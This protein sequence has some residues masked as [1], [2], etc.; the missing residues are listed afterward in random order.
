MTRSQFDALVREAMRAIPRRFRE[1]MQNVEILVEE[2]PDP[3]MLAD[4]GFDS[5]EVLALCPCGSVDVELL[6]GR[7]LR[8]RSVEV[9]V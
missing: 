5:D 1:R 7:E 6:R 3:A 4:M 2:A 8:I 9:A